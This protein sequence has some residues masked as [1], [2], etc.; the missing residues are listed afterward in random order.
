MLRTDR[1]NV[2]NGAIA[3]LLRIAVEAPLKNLRRWP[4][5]RH[6]LAALIGVNAIYLVTQLR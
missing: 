1:P 3:I 4:A 2:M 6:S 5:G